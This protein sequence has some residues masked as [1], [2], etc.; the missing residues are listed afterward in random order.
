MAKQK[1]DRLGLTR[2]NYLILLLAAI[3]LIVGY[4]IM[5]MNE[6][7]VSPVL[8]ALV[9]VIIIPFGLLYKPKVK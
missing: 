4:I 6:I 2:I 5:G 1:K 8:L 3:L 9:Y 7:N